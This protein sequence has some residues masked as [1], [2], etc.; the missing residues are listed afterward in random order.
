MKPVLVLSV[1]QFVPIFGALARKGYALEWARL[2]AW[3]VDSAPKQKDVGV[4]SCIASGF[5]G[6]VANLGWAAALGVI[7]MLLDNIVP[8]SN[9][10]LSNFITFLSEVAF[11]IYSI[12]SIVIML[13]ATIYQS[14]SAGYVPDKIIEMLKHDFGG[15][16]RIVGIKLLAGCIYVIFGVIMFV[17]ILAQALP[18]LMRFGYMIDLQYGAF[19]GYATELDPYIISEIIGMISA[20]LPLIIIA[21]FIYFVLSTIANL[22]TTT[23]VGLWYRQFNVPQWG[24][25][26]DPLPPFITETTNTTQH[27]PTDA[28]ARNTSAPSASEYVPEEAATAPDVAPATSVAP[29]APVVAA[30]PAVPATPAT[31]AE[32]A[33]PAV[34]TD[35]TLTEKAPE[36]VAAEEAA[37]KDGQDSVTDSAPAP[38]E[39]IAGQESQSL[40][41]FLDSDD[42]VARLDPIAAPE[43]ID[44]SNEQKTSEDTPKADADTEESTKGDGQTV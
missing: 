39:A 5:R 33:A 2:T 40:K 15:I 8:D 13:R 35:D 6:F 10:G 7:F 17:I 37:P 20:A 11:L 27:I 38:H 24:A 4:G 36:D 42:P 43:P 14:V 34:P 29:A 28:Q 3:G 18:N 1:A 31:P 9:E 44:F 23:A 41:E 25:S 30:Q 22:L 16:M 32:T 12:V 19:G 21:V 26:K